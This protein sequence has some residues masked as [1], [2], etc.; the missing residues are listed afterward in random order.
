VYGVSDPEPLLRRLIDEAQSRRLLLLGHHGPAGLG[1][2][3]HAPFGRDWC[4]SGGDHGDP[5]FARLLDHA[6]QRGKEVVLAVAGHMHD[7][8]R[9]RTREALRYSRGAPVLNA[10]RVPRLD[11]RDGEVWR[12]DYRAELTAGGGVR[13]LER[14][15]WVAGKGI[16]SRQDVFLLASERR[17]LTRRTP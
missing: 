13:K 4:A 10:C 9:G 3:P 1:T 12:W 15:A 5:L 11:R 7:D 17:A 8:C 16:V 6:E 14:T 2:E